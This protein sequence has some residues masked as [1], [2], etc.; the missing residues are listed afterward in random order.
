VSVRRV[1][2]TGGIASGKSLAGDYL[3]QRNIPVIDADDVVHDLLRDD[4]EIRTNIRTEFGDGVFSPDGQL[5]RKALG[6]AVFGDTPRRKLLESWIHP[7]TR[8]VIEAFYRANA[9][10]TLGVSIIPLLFESG[11]ENRYDEV[12]LIETPEEIQ[13]QRLREARAMLHEDAMARIRSQ[14]PY[15]EKQLRA[16]LHPSYRILRNTGKPE[17]L[18]GQLDAALEAIAHQP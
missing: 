3:R 14:M 9:D 6:L 18:Y 1:A 11:L 13:L 5:D 8:E 15:P 17:D 4:A 2:L 16:E 12:W 7:K 10:A